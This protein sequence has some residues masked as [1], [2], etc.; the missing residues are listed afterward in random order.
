[1]WWK[2]YKRGCKIIIKYRNKLSSNILLCLVK[3]NSLNRGFIKTPTYLPKNYV[4]N[5]FPFM[6]FYLVIQWKYL[7]TATFNGPILSEAMF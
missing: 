7:F 3:K 6:L 1:M 2:I 4:S 5:F